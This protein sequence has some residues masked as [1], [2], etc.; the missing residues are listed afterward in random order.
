[1]TTVHNK[2][3]LLVPLWLPGGFARG[4]RRGDN[5]CPDEAIHGTITWQQWLRDQQDMKITVGGKK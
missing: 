5:T 4:L 3:R 2:R 1:M